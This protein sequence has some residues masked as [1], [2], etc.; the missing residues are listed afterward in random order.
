MRK[1]H[2]KIREE[3]RRLYLTGEMGTNAEIATR[4]GVKPHTVG[5]WRRDE[6]WDDLRLKIDLRAAEMFVERL[7]T[8]RVSLNLRHYRLWD[9]LLGRLA[10]DLKSR[11]VTDIREL[12]RVA[13]ILERSQKG[14]R[15]AKGLSLTGENEETI[16]AQ[17]EAE[18]RH[19]I[20]V[21]IGSVKDN[22]TDEETRDAIRRHILEALP[23]E[24]GAGVGDPGD[25]VGQRST[26]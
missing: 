17:A 16:R 26:S 12:E 25:A 14:Q 8:D 3:A 22:V 24:E 6:D 5:K 21:F 11:A 23:E 1:S 15:L 2:A 9:L 13:S 10:E 7:A 19:L 18:T 4:L 20:D